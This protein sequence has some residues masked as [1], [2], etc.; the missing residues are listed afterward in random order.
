MTDAYE[1]NGLKLKSDFPLPAF[2]AWDGS[3]D[4][5]ADIAIRRGKVPSRLDRPDHVSPL[6]QTS[7]SGEYLLVLPGTGRILIRA[8]REIAV[9]P[10]ADPPAANLS[11]IL[12]GPIQAVLW[13]QRDLLPLHASV[14]V[15]KGRAIALCGCGAAGKSTLAAILAAHGHDVI[16]DDICVVDARSNGE[17]LVP[18]GCATLQLWP[19]ALA[20]LGVA[21]DGLKR[22][23]PDK[24]RY[25][26]DCGNRIPP[27][28]QRLVAVV[29]MVRHHTLPPATLE[30]LRG[31][32]AADALHENIH[33]QRP[34]A[35]LGR[36]QP[37]F[38][39]FARMASAGVSFWRLTV[40]EGLPGLR[41]AAAKMLAT[42]ED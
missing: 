33:S 21:T 27:E 2:A 14:V 16:A 31:T 8:G 26:Y 38:T 15:I 37:I 40:P 28:P 24:E 19:D 10:E 20:E 4:A 5:C 35:A 11:A 1:L 29:S 7:G 32:Q 30:R 9:E 6:F 36:A 23:V 12:A 42:L 25:L 18:P 41:E 17:V 22:A 39:A 13:H 3:R 34:A